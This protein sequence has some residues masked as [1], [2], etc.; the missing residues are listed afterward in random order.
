MKRL[1]IIQQKAKF[2]W[3][4]PIRKG[5]LVALTTGESLANVGIFGGFKWCCPQ[6]RENMIVAQS[7][8]E[9]LKKF[10]DVKKWSNEKLLREGQKYLRVD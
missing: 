7:R 5:P 6:K 9:A 4:F 3:I 10:H 1:Y 8:E 2:P